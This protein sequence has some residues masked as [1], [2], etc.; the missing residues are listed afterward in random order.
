MKGCLALRHVLVLAGCLSGLGYAGTAMVAHAEAARAL[1]G[2]DPEAATRPISFDIPAR[3]LAEALRLYA[4]VTRQP[5][6]FRSELVEGRISSAVRGQY[7]PEAALHRLLD[8]TGLIAETV[9]GGT[10]RAFV[11]KVA[12]AHPAPAGNGPGGLAGYPGL[13]QTGVWEA[14]CGNPRT[15]PGKY[16]LLL[17]FHIDVA[18]S[19]QG[20]RLLGSSGDTQQD[21]AILAGLQGMR[22]G[23]PPP[24]DMPQ[25]VTMVIL[26]G[27]TAG[28]HAGPGCG[29]DN[30]A[31][32]R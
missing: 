20:I 25:P 28:P 15:A 5:A 21:N 16:R 13:V 29:T 31:S 24:A 17:R 6:L 2:S 22:L 4:L 18:G 30:G 7:S 3:P 1:D 32:G 23:A 10:A 8:G 14:L 12:P 9:E 26:P 27:D 11:L 19:L